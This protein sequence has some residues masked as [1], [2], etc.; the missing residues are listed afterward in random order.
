LSFFVVDFTILLTLPYSAFILRLSGK[1]R[2]F[3]GINVVA[4][5]FELM[6]WQ[7]WRRVLKL[8][9]RV[10]AGVFGCRGGKL[11]YFAI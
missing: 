2:T 8:T 1:V 5:V 10:S 9:W 6:S 7:P 3:F 11:T 4:T